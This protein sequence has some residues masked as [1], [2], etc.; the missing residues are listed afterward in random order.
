M[1]KKQEE[2][3]E[4]VKYEAYYMMKLEELGAKLKNLSLVARN[5]SEEEG[6]YKIW[7]SRSN[8]EDMYHPT[9]NVMFAKHHGIQLNEKIVLEGFVD[10]SE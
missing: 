8:D 5:S 7:S 3:K 10:E 4:K 6:T 1:T 9:H 2:K